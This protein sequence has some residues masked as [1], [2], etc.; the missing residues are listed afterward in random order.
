MPGRNCEILIAGGGLGG[1]AAALAAAEMGRSVVMTEETAWIG[2]QIT[3]QGVSAFDEHRYIES[4]GGTARYRALREGIRAYYRAHYPLTAAARGERHLNPGGGRVSRLCHEPRV[5]LAVLEAML[6]PHVSAGRVTL[7]TRHRP[8][9][10]ET[11]S[12]RVR[13]VR[14][15]DL[16]EGAVVAVEAHMVCGATELGDR[17]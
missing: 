13:A 8:I 17:L 5:A 15:R 1:C 16:E 7:L 14:F 4:F 2:G 10:A 11:S 12:D 9:A 6:A 3:S